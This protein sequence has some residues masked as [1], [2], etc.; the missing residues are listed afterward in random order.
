MQPIQAA[1]LLNILFSVCVF[2]LVL[3]LIL[4]RFPSPSKR[5]RDLHVAVLNFL[6]GRD[7]GQCRGGD[8]WIRNQA[9]LS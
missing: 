8:L 5:R 6:E 1:I 7:G 4:A 9:V 2:I 3:I